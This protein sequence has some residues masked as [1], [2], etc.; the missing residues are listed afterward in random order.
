MIICIAL[1]SQ[2]SNLVMGNGIRLDHCSI[3]FHVLVICFVNLIFKY[4]G[5]ICTWK[6]VHMLVHCK[7]ILSNKAMVNVIYNPLFWMLDF[8]YISLFRLSWGVTSFACP[9]AIPS[10]KIQ[11]T[12]VHPWKWHF[13]NQKEAKPWKW[14]NMVRQF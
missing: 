4:G 5:R 8:L 1:W 9:Q 13:S 10:L 11:L 12:L 7:I 3:L 2:R 14:E 6:L